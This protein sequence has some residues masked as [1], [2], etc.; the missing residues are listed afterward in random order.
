MKYLITSDE[1]NRVTV[2]R[3]KMYEDPYFKYF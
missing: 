3:H 2:T 1:M